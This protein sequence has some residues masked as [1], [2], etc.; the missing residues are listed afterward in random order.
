M[1][2]AYI[3]QCIFNNLSGRNAVALCAKGPGI[4][5]LDNTLDLKLAVAYASGAQGVLGTAL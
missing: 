5:S 1:P 4:E 2:F 3:T